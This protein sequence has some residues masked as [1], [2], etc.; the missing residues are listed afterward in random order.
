MPQA[1]K[2]AAPSA[3][4]PA[5]PMRASTTPDILGC[6]ATN[7]RA[8]PMSPP[9][10]V[11]VLNLVTEMAAMVKDLR[12]QRKPSYVPTL[13]SPRL[14][15]P[16]ISPTTERRLAL[17]EARSAVTAAADSQPAKAAVNAL[18]HAGWR[19]GPPLR[20]MGRSRSAAT[21]HHRSRC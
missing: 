12:K 10:Q 9:E 17:A 16:P 1:T 21:R 2:S 13:S 20:W 5:I 18:R 4:M 6:M 3:A 11:Q 8:S 19:S 15:S 7:L 14:T